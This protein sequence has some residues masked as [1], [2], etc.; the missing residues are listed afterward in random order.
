MKR[1]EFIRHL[2]A[3]GCILLREGGKHSIY[4]NPVNGY[5]S[6]VPRHPELKKFTCLEI[7]KQLELRPPSKVS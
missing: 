6:A 4:K 1:K 5:L 2:E 3:Q 7:C